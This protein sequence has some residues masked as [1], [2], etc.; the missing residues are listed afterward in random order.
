MRVSDAS[1]D[2]ETIAVLEQSLDVAWD[3]AIRTIPTLTLLGRDGGNTRAVLARAVLEGAAA[4]LREPAELANFA[5]KS[6]PSFR[7]QS[8]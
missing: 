4:G 6:F 2:P 5:L 7:L 3:R 8:A 1:Y